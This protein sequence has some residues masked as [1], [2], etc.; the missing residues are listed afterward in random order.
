M[1]NPAGWLLISIL[2]ISN[3]EVPEDGHIQW[4]FSSVKQ[5]KSECN[6]EFTATIDHGWHLYSQSI[7]DGGPKPTTFKFDM[8]DD[9]RLLGK[10]V[11][12]GERRIVYDST[13]MMDVA[14]YEDKVMF[15]QRVKC[16]PDVKVTGEISYS[17]CSEE[18]C[19]PGT[20]RFSIDTRE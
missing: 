19:I 4:Y 5:D 16:R 10:V 9:V 3:V 6:L 11:E 13:F 18:R 14:W 12:I 2:T 15:T 8:R 7:E 20:V 17:V 1:F